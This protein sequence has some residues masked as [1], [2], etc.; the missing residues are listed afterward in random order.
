VKV[1]GCEPDGLELEAME[2]HRGLGPEE[3]RKVYVILNFTVEALAD[4]V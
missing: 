2:R 4:G 3:C 1:L